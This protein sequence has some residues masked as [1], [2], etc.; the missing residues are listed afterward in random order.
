[1]AG[2]GGAVMKNVHW[3]G[4][5]G[6]MITG[7]KTVYVDPYEIRGGKPADLILITHEHYDHCSP[8]DL[9]K[10]LAPDTVIVAAGGAG[11]K[12][13][14]RVKTVKPG[15]SLAECGLSIQAVPA[16]NFKLPNHARE[17]NHAGYVFTFDGVVYYHAGDTDYIPEM[18]QISADTAFLPVGGTVTMGPSE[19]ARA[20]ED[21]KAKTAIPMHWGSVIGSIEDAQKFCRLCKCEAVI[22]DME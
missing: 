12:L 7:S 20:A 22:P 19:A 1:M 21:V 10:I 4:H 6:F 14:G 5:A 18:K 9:Q 16:Y 2:I 8:G 11:A 13:A 3:L 17:K 15:D